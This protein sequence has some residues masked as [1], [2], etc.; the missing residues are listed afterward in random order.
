VSFYSAEFLRL[1]GETAQSTA[2]CQPP[3][4]PTVTVAAVFSAVDSS[5]GSA[6]NQR[7]AIFKSLHL[8]YS[9]T[10]IQKQDRIVV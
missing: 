9:Y 7:F 1:Q 10:I 2:L 8:H 3:R 5:A 6:L 4:R